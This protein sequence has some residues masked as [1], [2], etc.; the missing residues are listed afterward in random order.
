ANP[1]AQAKGQSFAALQGREASD[2]GQFGLALRF[3]VAAID[4]EFG[5]YGMNVHSK[6]P[7]ISAKMGTHP[8][9][10]IK[11]PGLPFPIFNPAANAGLGGWFSAVAGGVPQYSFLSPADFHRT[12][13]AA[14]GTPISVAG[15]F[16]EYPEDIQIYGL[17]AATTLAGWSVAAEASYQKDVPVQ[18]NGND[19]LQAALLGAGPYGAAGR[20]A[21]L[22]GA[23]TELPGYEQFDKTQFQA[24]AVKSFSNVLGASSLLLVGE[25][26]VQSND[27]PDFE[28]AGNLRFGRAFI[29]GNGIL[30]GATAPSTNPQPDGRRN[31]G[32]V[33]DLAWGY[34]VR[35]R[36]DY[37]GLSGGALRLSPSLV[38]N[39]DVDGVAMDGQFIE[40]RQTLG[41][42]L[43]FNWSKKYTVDLN[44]TWFADSAFNPLMDRDYF[45]VSAGV[46]F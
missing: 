14:G 21:V 11:T 44:Y 46:N 15:G 4:T 41:A 2:T 37:D 10:P 30:P 25:I 36:L 3:P 28:Q 34:R 1:V 13:A 17:T 32:Y 45:S 20:A 26:G 7:V 29:Y 22:Q 42:G 31:D 38:W 9:V 8:S 24:N 18:I 39:H 16:W 23:G 19:L 33:T 27:V 12:L 6:I 5:L 35:A 43:G 40:G